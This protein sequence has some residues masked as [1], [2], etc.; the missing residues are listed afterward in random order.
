MIGSD[1]AILHQVILPVSAA[2]FQVLAG[3]K[4]ASDHDR[5][6]GV[7]GIA[8]MQFRV[9]QLGDVV[10][11]PGGRSMRI[12]RNDIDADH[13]LLQM[14]G[15]PVPVLVRRIKSLWYVDAASIIAARKTATELSRTLPKP[16]TPAPNHH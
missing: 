13:V 9:L 1:T 11:L 4:P 10:A 2:D 14:P 6:T 3:A 7:V 12:T 8:S 15:G 5:A 16:H